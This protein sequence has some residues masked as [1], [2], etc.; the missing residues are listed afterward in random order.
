MKLTAIVIGIALLLSSCSYAASLEKRHQIGLRVGMWNQ[1]TGVRSEVDVWGVTTS[2]DASGYLGGVSY[3]HWLEE[4]LALTIDIGGM[5]ADVSTS[6]GASGVTTET[7][8]IGSIIVGVK[9]YFPKSTYTSSVR[10]YARAGVGPFIGSQSSTDVGTSVTVE[11]R[12]ENAFGGQLGAGVDFILRRHFMTGFAVCYNLMTDFNQ[13]VGGSR[14][15]SGPEF[16]FGFSYLFG[17]GVN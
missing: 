4:Y 15:Y 5:A 8:V 14:N 17:E 13:P 7:S 6:S 16:S 1:T 2:V 3:G 12:S 9:A 11:S 10:P